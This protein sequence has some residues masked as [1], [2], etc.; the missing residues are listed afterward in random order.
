MVLKSIHLKAG[1]VVFFYFLSLVFFSGY[2]EHSII[3]NIGC[4]F[5]LLILIIFDVKS[6][7][8]SSLTICFFSLV[9]IL[10]SLNIVTSESQAYTF[11]NI[12]SLLYS[13]CLLLSMYIMVIDHPKRLI[14]FLRKGAIPF[15][16]IYIINIYVLYKQVSNV[17]LFIKPEWMRLNPYYPDLCSGTFG[18]NSTNLYVLFVLFM[19]LYNTMY[20][21]NYVIKPS[22]R[23]LIS[24]YSYGTLLLLL[25]LCTMNDANSIFLFLPVVLVS[26]LIV[27]SSKQKS[28]ITSKTVKKAGVIA[29]VVVLFIIVLLKVPVIN[30]YI[31]ETVLTRLHSMLTETDSHKVNGSNERIAIALYGLRYKWGWKLGRGIGYSKWQM[32]KMFGFK[33]FGISSI[34][35]FINLMGV[36]FYLAYSMLMTSIIFEITA[37]YNKPSN[38]FLRFIGLFLAVLLLSCYTYIFTGTRM[39]CMVILIMIVLF[40]TKAK[41]ITEIIA[42]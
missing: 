34:G 16:I 3:W 17:P 13:A 5:S 2:I 22:H 19:F 25:Y 10:L 31:E 14:E 41:T 11:S 7:H 24:I 32:D 21:E 8:T 38:K 42:K 28:V 20:A 6:W 9:M 35:S 37:T 40:H 27:T 26:K 4:V 33:H 30:E 36:W 12:R 29:V 39:T 18:M 23:L 15:N 1:D